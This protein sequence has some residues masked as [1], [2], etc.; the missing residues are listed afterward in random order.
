MADRLQLEIVT[1]AQRVVAE[2]VDEVIVPAEDGYLG[3][4]FGHA[5]MLLRLQ[6]GQ[7]TYRL[8]GKS[9]VLAIS[10]GYAEV[11]RTS[12]AV[13]AE[14]CEPAEK[15]DVERANRAKERAERRLSGSDSDSDA[16]R[17]EVSLKRAMNRISAHTHGRSMM[18]A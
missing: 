1:P 12:V 4:R 11:T 15:V 10:G 8:D 18:G 2:E 13:L 17:A 3:V 16:Q 6:V 14:T 9:H 7:L 5:P